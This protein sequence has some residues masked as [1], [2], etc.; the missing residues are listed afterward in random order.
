V[1]QP[2]ANRIGGTENEM[3]IAYVDKHNRPIPLG[4]ESLCSMLL[5]FMRPR[6]I[7]G[8]WGTTIP[9]SSL[10]FLTRVGSRLYNDHCHP[11]ITT[12]ETFNPYEIARYDGGVVCLMQQAA[13]DFKSRQGD[14][15]RIVL[16]KNNF[17]F[18]ENLRPEDPV[19]NLR[20]YKTFG[21]HVNALAYRD[22]VVPFM[23][24]I[25]SMIPLLVCLQVVCGAGGVL[26][27][28]DGQPSFRISNRAP[29]IETVAEF[30]S[31][32]NRPIFNL[33]DRPLCDERRF[34]RIHIISQDVNM[35]D[36]SNLLKIG[37]IWAGL[38]MTECGCSPGRHL[39]LDNAVMAIRAISADPTLK[40]TVKLRHQDRRITGL[41]MLLAY[42]E[43]MLVH[44]ED[45]QDPEPWV[46][47]Y[48]ELM[49]G[50]L[51]GLSANP[52]SQ[53]HR[54]DWVAKYLIIQK[55]D[56]GVRHPRAAAI[57]IDYHR[58]GRGGL[59][60][61]FAKTGKMDRLFSEEEIQDASQTPPPGRP[62]A[63]VAWAKKHGSKVGAR[64]EGIILRDAHGMEN[65]L[66]IMDPWGSSAES[67]ELLQ[68]PSFTEV[69]RHRGHYSIPREDMTLV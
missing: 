37:T 13:D 25:E 54:L 69:L 14:G 20:D 46:K 32:E 56:G 11:E 3:G 31:T 19:R 9:S 60:A 17:G 34:R 48:L 33:R 15:S 40:Q 42:F 52:L 65:L 24:Y 39:S 16:H 27:V 30:S 44:Y 41:E 26:V 12:P 57:D 35:S 23:F 38:D 62:A 67:D 66:R 6:H 2:I 49:A 4:N 7:L 51:E 36:I 53:A 8:L 47:P 5:G 1:V 28:S 58:L 18:S 68:I 29:F 63:R 61:H 10:N 50:V 64:W 21:G 59:H 43:Q 55:L 45:H 22:H